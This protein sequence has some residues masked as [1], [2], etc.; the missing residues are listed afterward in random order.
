[1]ADGT[2]VRALEFVAISTSGDYLT[3]GAYTIQKLC[4]TLIYPHLIAICASYELTSSVL[5]VPL[6]VR[7][8]NPYMGL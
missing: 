1:M 7:V 5:L 3:E 2:M 6:R 8:T 4:V